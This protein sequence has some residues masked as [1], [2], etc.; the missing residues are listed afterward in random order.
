MLI[1]AN[2]TPLFSEFHLSKFLFTHDH[3]TITFSNITDRIFKF[4]MNKPFKTF[5]NLFK[6]PGDVHQRDKQQKS[7][8]MSRIQ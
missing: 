3:H 2:A 8:N 6:G 1:V 4:K 5:F 7:R